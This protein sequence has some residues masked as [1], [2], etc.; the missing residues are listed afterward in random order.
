MLYFSDATDVSS[1]PG[2]D[3][4]YIFP[5]RPMFCPSGTTKLC[6]RYNILAAYQ[7]FV[8]PGQQNCAVG[9]IYWQ[10]TN[11]LSRWDK[12]RYIIF[13]SYRCFVPPGQQNCAVGT[14]YR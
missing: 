2:R 4:F 14:I 11:V 7:C 3:K 8:P 13:P 5:L 9:T 12:L 1:H 10:P 6:R